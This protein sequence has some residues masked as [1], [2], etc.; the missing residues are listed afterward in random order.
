MFSSASTQRS[1]GVFYTS[2]RCSR[3]LYGYQESSAR[4]KWSVSTA[5]RPAGSIMFWYSAI[6]STSA[7]HRANTDIRPLDLINKLKMLWRTGLTYRALCFMGNVKLHLCCSFISHPHR[8]CGQSQTARISEPL[9]H[10]GS[11]PPRRERT[12]CLTQISIVCA[13]GKLTAE[14][15]T[16]CS[17]LGNVLLCFVRTKE[18]QKHKASTFPVRNMT[19]ACDLKI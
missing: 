11:S 10:Y 9:I 8:W 14:G 1:V 5:E 13:D 2:P 12:Y 15:S 4:H 7:Q 19:K 6:C 3:F 16:L 18:C 17:Y